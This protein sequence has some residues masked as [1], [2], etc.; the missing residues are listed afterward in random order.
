MELIDSV[1]TNI[2]HGSRVMALQSKF[3]RAFVEVSEKKLG[4]IM[5]VEP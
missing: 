1:V 3:L 5:I 2:P 4:D